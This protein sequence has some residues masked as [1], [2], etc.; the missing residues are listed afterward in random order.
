MLESISGVPTGKMMRNK[1]VNQMFNQE[2]SDF[3]G[4]QLKD[5]LIALDINIVDCRYIIKDNREYIRVTSKC[6]SQD[7][8]VNGDS[9]LAIVYGVTR[10]LLF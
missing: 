7:I 3:V 5:L 1:E 4:N 8:C 6:G 9:L 2:K 10:R